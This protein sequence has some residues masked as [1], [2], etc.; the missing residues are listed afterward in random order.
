MIR[1]K[2]VRAVVVSAVGVWC[3]AGI[4]AAPVSEKPAA[5]MHKT[6]A[7]TKD[8]HKEFTR[9]DRIDAIRRAQVWTATEIPSMNLKA[10]PQGAVAFAPDQTV[11]CEYT[12]HSRG[13]GSTPKFRCTVPPDEELKVRYRQ[14]NGHVYAQVAATRLLWALGFG[15]NRVYPVKVA[16]HGCPWDPWATVQKEP[17]QPQVI[18]FDPASIDIKMKGKT[19]ETKPDEGWAWKELDQV[20][21]TAGGA[22]R[23]QLDALKLLAVFIQHTDTKASNQLLLCLDK[24]L[25]KKEL[26]KRDKNSAHKAGESATDGC[27]HPFMTLYDV[28]LTFGHANAMNLNMPGSANFKEWSAA[29]IWKDKETEKGGCIGNLG[30]SIS[31]TLDNP[32]IS[33]AGRKFLA[34][35]LVQLSD[36]QLHDLFD[37]ARFTQRDRSASIDDWVN[38]FKHKRDEIVNRTCSS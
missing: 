21:Q 34:D 30:G 11:S 26:D 29:L 14:T 38:A 6:A 20:D 33:E 24:E 13:S 36:A 25:D 31:G 4:H 35:L 17:G 16:C 9:Q 18:L 15:A 12:P 3:V 23:A 8:S 28:G 27:A 10:G 1:F 5:K 37:V 7:P 32:R 22:T 2:A 19:L